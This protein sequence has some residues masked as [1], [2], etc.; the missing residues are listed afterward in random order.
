LYDAGTRWDHVV[1][2]SPPSLALSDARTIAQLVEGV[3]LV[4]GDGTDRASLKR[5]QQAFDGA[6][7]RLLGF[8][9]NRVNLDD[10]NYGYYREYGNYYYDSASHSAAGRSE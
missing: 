8:V 1:I 3:V 7:I 6:G 5:T 4:V 2:D 10:M 9:M